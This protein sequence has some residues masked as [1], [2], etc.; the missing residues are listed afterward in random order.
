MA[1]NIGGNPWISIWTRPKATIRSIVDYDPDYRL[2]VLSAIYGLVS[3]ISTC[4][5]FAL[6]QTVNLFFLLI[7][8]L[9]LAPFWGYFV[10]SIS[11]F[12]IQLTGKWLKGQANYKEIRASIAWSNVPMIGNLILWI[13]LL[14]IFKENLLKD[15]PQSY[16]ISNL[17]RGI[18][19]GVLLTQLV[20]SIWVLVIYINSLAEVQKFSIGKAI[21][22]IILSVILFVG[23]FFIFSIIYFL[24]L[25]GFNI[26]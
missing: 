5:S 24:I 10:F 3:L 7:S 17:E 26:K 23:L 25:K 18:L 4:Q 14:I 21:L 2:F 15:F 13:F 1:E 9:I 6:G 12:I 16:E 22:N 11:A 8:C 20:L 19:F